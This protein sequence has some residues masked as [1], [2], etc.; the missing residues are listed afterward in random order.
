MEEPIKSFSSQSETIDCAVCKQTITLLDPSKSE[1]VVCGS[2]F[3]YL[4]II[5]NNYSRLNR[6]LVKPEQ[7]PV[8]KIGSTATFHNVNF[9]LIAYLEKKEAGSDY[10]WR[11]YILTSKD[12]GY[13]TLS[14][15]DGHWNLIG[16]K[17]FLI[18]YEE[19]TV[20]APSVYY[21]NIE[22]RLFNKYT[23]I[24]TAMVGEVDWDVVNEKIKAQEYIAPPFMVVAET[25]ANYR[26]KD[27]YIGEYL[28]PKAIADAFGIDEIILTERIGIGANQPSIA[29]DR[30]K[31]ALQITAI[32]IVL[33]LIIHLL[34]GL[35]K[36]EKEL[37][38]NDFLISH[39]ERQDVNDYKSFITPSFTI[40][41]ESSN[42]AFEIATT[43]DNNWLE[44]TIVLVNEKDN[45]T[46]EV[47]KSIEYYHGYE[48]GEGWSEGSTRESLLLSDIPKGTYHLNVYPSSGDINSNNLY[49]KA[50][51]NVTMWRNTLITILLLCL[52]PAVCWYMMRNFEKRRWDNS[53]YSPFVNED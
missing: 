6:Q 42:V 51:A 16:G 3:S 19:P 17:D 10:C 46:W 34:I 4:H 37:L 40:D 28:E 53:D 20:Q 47:S 44:T 15:F 7:K 14:E 45:R 23:P 9:K 25:S 5:A 18:D 48:G 12:R 30:F 22:Y 50:T 29:Y 41:D 27:Y 32:A 38:N 36:P 52:Y 39:D 33:V 43:V 24:V 8:L 11:E 21:K 31:S 49:I 2:C 26:N 35:V 13:I 1:Y